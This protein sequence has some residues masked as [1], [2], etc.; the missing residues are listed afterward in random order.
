MV[1]IWPPG[2]VIGAKPL[3]YVIVNE[4]IACEKVA[5]TTAAVPVL[6]SFTPVAVLPAIITREVVEA[7]VTTGAVTAV[8]LLAPVKTTSS[9]YAFVTWLK[10][11]RSTVASTSPT[12]TVKL[13]RGRLKVKV[14]DDVPAVD[15]K[16]LVQVMGVPAASVWG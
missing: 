12:L 7:D 5:V 2:L 11:F 8:P 15:E 14:T 10:I 13:D 6:P 4:L 1:I 16:S 9:V 3:R